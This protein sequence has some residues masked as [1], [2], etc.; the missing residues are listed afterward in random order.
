MHIP[1]GFLDAKTVVATAALAALG[2]GTALRQA[3]RSLPPRRVPILGLTA[4]FVF[5][6]QM[7]NFPV[8]G[9]TSGHLMGAVLAAV[10]LGPGGAVLVLTAV[11]VVQSLVFADGGLLALGANVFNMGI[12]GGVGGYALYRAAA[13]LGGGD[14]GR[15]GASAFAAWGS[16]VLAA[17]LVAGELT[18][19]GVAAWAVVLPAM[20]GVHM[21]I[22]VGEALI[23]ALVVL[24]LLRTRPELLDDA[25]PAG[26]S[27][28]LGEVVAF[29][30]VIALGIGLFV[31]PF[32]SAWP[33]GL[34]KVAERLGF[35]GRAV[36]APLVPAPAPDYAFPG[37]SSAGWATALA[38][39]VGTVVVFV[40]SFALARVLVPTGTGSIRPPESR[41][42]RPR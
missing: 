26:P 8:A 41:T 15:L 10:L 5:A 38:G 32:A 42:G 17:V 11:L 31:S 22:G 36:E 9:G 27:R 28:P 7:V 39:G 16:I 18:L 29:G 30:L 6:A 4:A 13:R 23:T 25:E 2:V 40:L 24:A 34:E 33:D 14:R 37:V 21:L 20:A 19:S 35:L 12:V 1:D 3:R